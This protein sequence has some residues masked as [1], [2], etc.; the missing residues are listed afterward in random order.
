MQWMI[1]EKSFLCNFGKLFCLGGT[2]KWEKFNFRKISLK[3]PLT[4]YFVKFVLKMLWIKSKLLV[5]QICITENW[6]TQFTQRNESTKKTK[7]NS[8]S[9]YDVINFFGKNMATENLLVWIIYVEI[10]LT[11]RK[12]KI[13][14]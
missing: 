2:L 6:C 4:F 1:F 13:T 3:M 8:I 5:T 10:F 11:Y 7:I 12:T 14:I 9:I